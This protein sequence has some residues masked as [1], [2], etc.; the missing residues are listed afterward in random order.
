MTINQLAMHNVAPRGIAGSCVPTSIV[1]A[2][3]V[4]YYDVEE[5]LF[6]EQPRNW[7]PDLR[8][9][10][11]VETHKLFGH[12]RKIFGHTF[13]KVTHWYSVYETS[14][15]LLNGTYLVRIHRHVFVIKDGQ[16]FDLNETRWT[17][18]VLDVWKV[19]KTA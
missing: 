17:E 5:V 8:G 11:G 13:T 14:Q 12:T 2:T 18:K 19:E 10:S 3:G 9:N 6:H 16:V 15:R 7:K 4:S 1:F